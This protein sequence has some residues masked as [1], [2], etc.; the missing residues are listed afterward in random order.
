MLFFHL[1]RL[2]QCP[3]M[4]FNKTAVD[5][6]QTVQNTVARLLTGTKRREDT[7]LVS[8]RSSDLLVPLLCTGF[9]TREALS[10][11]TTAIGCTSSIFLCCIESIDS[12]R[13]KPKTYLFRQAETVLASLWSVL[14]SFF[15]NL[16]SCFMQCVTLCCEALCSVYL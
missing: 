13:K 7:T 2:L 11:S 16:L 15:F 9:T 6:L 4:C 1:F 3:F 8:L 10:C 12:F 14:V 5:H